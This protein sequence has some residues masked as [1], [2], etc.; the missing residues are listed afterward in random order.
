MNELI[1]YDV[2]GQDMFGAGITAKDIKAQIDGFGEVDEITVRIN[3]PGGDVFEGLAIYNLLA[4]HPATITVKVDGYAASIASVIAMAGDTVTMAANA[5]FMIHNPYTFA[6]GD[7]ADL[8]EKADV[9]ETVKASL[10]TTYQTKATADD[11]ELSNLMDSETWFNAEQSIEHGFATAKTGT[12]AKLSNLAGFKWLNHA[13]VIPDA[14]EPD[15]KPPVDY[16]LV[17]L[18]RSLEIDSA[19]VDITRARLALKAG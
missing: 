18:A 13:P 4:E 15:T 19:R 9:L 11:N 12:D 8:R 6:F 1:L 5:L 17:A 3:S 14:P 2:I 7:S 16:R 10:I